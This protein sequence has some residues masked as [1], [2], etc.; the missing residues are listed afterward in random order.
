MIPNSAT[1]ALQEETSISLQK[2][3]NGMAEGIIL[4]LHVRQTLKGCKWYIGAEAR[5]FVRAASE[6]IYYVSKVRIGLFAG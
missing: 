4:I 3:A 2:V 1:V 6:M 5:E